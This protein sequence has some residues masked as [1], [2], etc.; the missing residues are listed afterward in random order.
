M[1]YAKEWHRGIQDVPLN[2]WKESVA[3]KMPRALRKKDDLNVLLTRIA[4]CA[5]TVKGVESEGL[6][7]GGK[8][9]E[10][11][12][13]HPAFRADMRVKVRIDDLDVQNAWV[14]NPWTGA[15]EKLEPV[16]KDYMSGLNWYAHDVARK[17]RLE[18][19]K[20]VRKESSMSRSKK[21]HREEAQEFIDG[22]KGGNRPRVAA[23]RVLGIG[24]RTPSGDDLGGVLPDPGIPSAWQ[25]PAPLDMS[26]P[27]PDATVA[28]A[29]PRVGPR[30]APRR[31][32]NH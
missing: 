3:R 26:V 13:A 8:A 15:D 18:T 11:I 28:A 5:V 1:I 23:V 14:I 16:F 21:R 24:S 20:G 10:R 30:P 22:K 17:D 9:L 19:G 29:V 12:M 2:R 25:P 31:V 32:P 27:A 4:E 6:R 7:W